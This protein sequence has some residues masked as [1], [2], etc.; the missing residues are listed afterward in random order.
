MA[1]R[2]QFDHARAI[3]LAY[4]EGSLTDESLAE[5]SKSIRAQLARTSA[6]A[7]IFDFT[8]VTEFKVSTDIVQHHARDGAVAFQHFAGVVIVP[9]DVAY[10][11]ARM[12]QI[13]TEKTLPHF[14]A[15]KTMDEAINILQAEGA[16][17]EP[18]DEA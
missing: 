1:I 6:R 11:L 18:L 10:G 8:G 5:V 2:F 17:F 9:R 3:L 16:Q 12:F 15:V 13:M 7:G 14:N 4:V